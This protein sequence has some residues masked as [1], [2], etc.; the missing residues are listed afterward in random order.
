MNRRSGKSFNVDHSS[1]VAKRKGTFAVPGVHSGNDF[2][3]LEEDIDA[4]NRRGGLNA[5]SFLRHIPQV[6]VERIGE[7]WGDAKLNREEFIKLLLPV[8]ARSPF[9][10]EN[11][12]RVEELWVKEGWLTHHAARLLQRDQRRKALRK[13]AT[14][15]HANT[16]ELNRGVL[17]ADSADIVVY[18]HDIFLVVDTARTGTVTW[19]SF[20]LYLIEGISG[21]Q[22][23]KSVEAA[24][25]GKPKGDSGEPLSYVFRGEIPI[26]SSKVQKRTSH[27]WFGKLRYI[28]AL[29]RIL[30]ISRNRF[31]YVLPNQVQLIAA[32]IEDPFTHHGMNYD[33]IVLSM[34]YTICAVEY[35]A[36]FEASVVC[37]IE[38]KPVR[39][40]QHSAN[41]TTKEVLHTRFIDDP[42]ASPPSTLL[43][44]PSI[45]SLWVGTREGKVFSV[46]IV[47]DDGAILRYL[48][49]EVVSRGRHP[50]MV[51]TIYQLDH[52][53]TIISG[54]MDGSMRVY[55]PMGEPRRHIQGIHKHGITSIVFQPQYNVLVT[56]GFDVGV[57]VWAD[58]LWTKPVFTL[59]DRVR[60]MPSYVVGIIAVP[61]TPYIAVGDA[62]G[63]IKMFDLRNKSV[64]FTLEVS[65]PLNFE[66]GLVRRDQLRAELGST[67]SDRG[68][69]KLHIFSSMAFTGPDHRQFLFGGARVFYFGMMADVQEN[70]S[71]TYNQDKVLVGGIA[72][73]RYG[74]LTVGSEEVTL[75]SVKTGMPDQ[76]Q[77]RLTA[78]SITVFHLEVDRN[79]IY[80]GHSDGTVSVHQSTT[81]I[82]L[83]QY[84][85]H[86]QSVVALA[87][88]HSEP[89][90]ASVCVGQKLC[91][92]YDEPLFGPKASPIV[93][94]CGA[95]TNPHQVISF[96][97]Q[98]CRIEFH[99]TNIL[100]LVLENAL[101][102]YA[103][104]STFKRWLVNVKIKLGKVAELL[105]A[106]FLYPSS[107]D[108]RDDMVVVTA[109][110]RGRFT[111]W[112][113]RCDQSGK[114]EGMFN[115]L[116][117]WSNVALHDN[118]RA[119]ADAVNPASHVDHRASDLERHA[120]QR[121]NELSLLSSGSKSFYME[122]QNASP[123]GKASA[124]EIEPALMEALARTEKDGVLS[125]PLRSVG[126]DP[127]HPYL[128]YS[129]D[130]LGR[131]SIWFFADRYS[132]KEAAAGGS[133]GRNLVI[134]DALELEESML[135][136]R[137]GSFNVG[138]FH[139]ILQAK[140]IGPKCIHSFA[141][142]SQPVTSIRVCYSPFHCLVSC[143]A[144]NIVKL[145][146]WDGIEL[147]VLQQGPLA[148]RS[149]TLG[150]T[151]ADYKA[152]F[153]PTLRWLRLRRYVRDGGHKIDAA[154]ESSD[155]SEDTSR[156]SSLP[157]VRN[158]SPLFEQTGRTAKVMEK[159]PRDVTFRFEDILNRTVLNASVGRSV[160]SGSSFS[161]T[162]Y[163]GN[164]TKLEP[165]YKVK[166]PHRLV[167]LSVTP[168][169]SFAPPPKNRKTNHDERQAVE[170][171]RRALLESR[172]GR[173]RPRQTSAQRNAIASHA[174]MHQS[175]VNHDLKPQGAER[176][177]DSLRKKK[178]VIYNG[179]S[180]WRRKLK[181]PDHHKAESPRHGS[182][183]RS[184]G[185]EASDDDI[186]AMLLLKE[187]AMFSRPHQRSPSPSSGRKEH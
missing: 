73:E 131:I 80:L 187:V 37:T 127:K 34:D 180:V 133:I 110:N 134:P 75:W 86:D 105:D 144:E 67:A 184:E 47:K 44:I 46:K 162:V 157:A 24:E 178:D 135:D 7:D 33:P 70:P 182:P 85:C 183:T 83:Q 14:F 40:L 10:D 26:F 61:A 56:G 149:W 169:P 41:G 66:R 17:P 60:P 35:L 156:S 62:S 174:Q 97:S 29:D 114:G 101:L 151:L 153:M 88:H 140:A 99:E 163:D 32:Q 84:L 125:P 58:N 8:V 124:E 120:S 176:Q 129:G 1:T 141:A 53:G 165:T 68:D 25:D 69:H 100:M 145:S 172:E 143:G 95:K 12:N 164:P 3:M 160:V 55:D 81:G 5:A 82:Q 48:V 119:T 52:S 93:Q 142:H 104:N 28:P 20:T 132:R 147:G 16:T 9:F 155:P 112:R 115:L 173:R 108:Q 45:G 148:D 89:M 30:A 107:Q 123:V 91:V 42:E 152:K 39:I 74:V 92:W 2:V 177:F 96:N 87:N 72:D 76:R 43:W 186:R 31:A 161:S 128:M 78:N 90:L 185:S 94:Q 175:P 64:I 15:Y 102:F 126:L 11:G 21:R 113:V 179:P 36:E 50:E 49:N 121:R 18:L 109:D 111:V 168:P 57:N 146:T 23:P 38:S 98:P 59:E 71:L 63:M 136:S 51:T 170:L 159:A 130:D 54:S 4:P 154:M 139:T 150:S 138:S 65:D 167:P 117:L 171:K 166:M 137:S 13:S 103:F 116:W 6:D 79:L 118:N 106:K 158:A 181:R 22:D 27:E 122:E 77:K 19:E